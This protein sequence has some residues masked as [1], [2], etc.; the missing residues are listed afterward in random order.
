LGAQRKSLL[1]RRSSLAQ[2]TF[3]AR[4]ASLA[5]RKLE[6][7]KQLRSERIKRK[8]TGTLIEEVEKPVRNLRERSKESAEAAQKNEANLKLEV[9]MKVEQIKGKLEADKNAMLVKAIKTV[10]EKLAKG[11]K[12]DEETAST[13]KKIAEGQLAAA[14]KPAAKAAK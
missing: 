13:V 8:Y 4:R 7:D 11:E 2:N 3:D 1:E 10:Q 12:I 6:I 5:D 9:N 14:A